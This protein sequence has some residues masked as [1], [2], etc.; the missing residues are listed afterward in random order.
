MSYVSFFFYKAKLKLEVFYTFLQFE[1]EAMK[2]LTWYLE[3]Q[4]DKTKLGFW[5]SQTK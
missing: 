5:W 3:E 4:A 2:W 1:V